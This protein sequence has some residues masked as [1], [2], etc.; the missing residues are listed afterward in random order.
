MPTKF[1]VKVLLRADVCLLLLVKLQAM[2]APGYA[3]A[4]ILLTQ[5]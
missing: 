2:P 3:Y 4:E 5:L 1:T